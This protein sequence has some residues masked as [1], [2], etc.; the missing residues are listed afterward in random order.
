MEAMRLA[1]HKTCKALQLS[2]IDDVFT[3]IVATRI[4]ELA[5][6]G[7]RARPRPTLQQSTGRTV[8]AAESFL[9]RPAERSPRQA[10]AGPAAAMTSR[11]ALRAFL[12]PFAFGEGLAPAI[13]KS[14]LAGPARHQ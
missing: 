4:V 3:D 11:L 8:R 12:R 13:R 10:E 7:E 1:F 6:T 14:L 9:A 5:K 2:D